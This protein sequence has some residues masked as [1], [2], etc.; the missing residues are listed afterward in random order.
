MV[1]LLL[2]LAIALLSGAAIGAV[3]A[4]P[5]GAAG[6][7]EN[8]PSAAI[9]RGSYLATA[10]DCA[11]CHT[12]PGSTPFAGGRALKTP[13]GT[14]YTPNITADPAT[15]I[16]RWS[17]ADFLRAVK[18]GIAPDGRYYFPVFP[19]PSFTGISDR[20]ALAI[21]AYLFSLPAIAQPNRPH[22]IGAPFSWRFLQFFWRW[23]YFQPGDF[24]PRA[25]RSPSWNRGAYLVRALGHCGECHT[26]RDRL[27]GLARHQALAGTPDGPDN[28]VVPNITPDRQT[29]I[30][31]WDRADIVELLKSG[32]KPDFDNVQGAMAEVVRG[33]TGRLLPED[34]Q[35]IADY[36]QSLPPIYHKIKRRTGGNAR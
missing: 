23:L 18:H 10:A 11:G 19:Y 13:F 26:P 8:A 4:G 32:T 2:V 35:A 25:D 7:A 33:S 36:L 9:T 3:A 16:G 5:S 15:G 17:D 30:G 29:G 14:F 20:D 1:V 12:S 31:T 34:R 22:Q 28:Q 21:K 6:G 27:G 24:R